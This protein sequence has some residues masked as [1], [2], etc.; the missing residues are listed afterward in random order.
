MQLKYGV[1][2]DYAGQGAAGKAIL[3]GIFDTIFN[4]QNLDT[5]VTPPF[6]LFAS[7]EAHVTEGSEHQATIHVISADGRDLPKPVKVSLPFRFSAQGPGR[8]LIGVL[9]IGIQAIELP[10]NGAY[11]FNLLIDNRHIAAVPLYVLQTPVAPS[12]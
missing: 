3:V 8:P 10:G 12:V 5:V 7:I 2:A 9:I 11:E 4:I 6:Y 1:L